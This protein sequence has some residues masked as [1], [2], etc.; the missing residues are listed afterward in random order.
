MTRWLLGAAYDVELIL[1]FIPQ[2]G[3]IDDDSKCQIEVDSADV[4][5]M[6]VKKDGLEVL[7]RGK[8][9]ES[10]EEKR[11]LAHI[12]GSQAIPAFA[13]GDYRPGP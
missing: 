5:C 2:T 8:P 3:M 1:P 11:I 6:R 10:E 7:G 4:G 12:R 9:G 13:S